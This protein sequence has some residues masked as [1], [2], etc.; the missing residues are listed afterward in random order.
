[1]HEEQ[2]NL[3]KD[4]PLNTKLLVVQYNTLREEILKRMEIENQLV[5]FTII[6]FGTILG[7]GYQ[8]KI[9]SLILI[10][11]MIA[12]FVIILHIHSEY[13]V[14]QIAFYIKDRIESVVGEVNIGWETYLAKNRYSRFYLGVGGIVVTTELIAIVVG[15]STV[16]FSTTFF[17]V[18]V[19]QSIKN[20]DFIVNMLLG[21][22]IVSFLLTLIMLLPFQVKP[23]RDRTRIRAKIDYRAMRLLLK[24]IH[25]ISKKRE[26][27]KRNS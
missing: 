19:G 6:V 27:K 2:N 22:A 23:I 7:I 16:P 1:M 11:P 8:N 3:Q 21:I 5:T 20:P 25:A 24:P 10:Y 9:T 15:I 17:A 4:K 18:L 26:I 14:N 12:L 13:H